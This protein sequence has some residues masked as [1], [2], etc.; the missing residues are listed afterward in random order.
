MKS[1]F[2]IVTFFLIGNPSFYVKGKS[3]TGYVFEKDYFVFM[4]IDYSDKRFT[5]SMKDILL[6]ESI[7]DQNIKRFNTTLKNQPKGYPIIHKNLKKYFRQYVG[8]INNSDEKII[9]INFLWKKKYTKE[10]ISKE[11]IEVNDGGSYYWN[12]K[13]NLQTME[14]MDFKVNGIG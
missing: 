3:F 2:L 9:W 5:P 8:F 14:L 1:F 12:I 11:I 10:G 7:L 6:A 13:I 4:T